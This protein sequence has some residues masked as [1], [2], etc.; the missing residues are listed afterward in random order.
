[1]IIVY[2]SVRYDL[3]VLLAAINDITAGVPLIGASSSGQ[4]HDGELFEQGDGLSVLALAGGGYQFGIG[5]ASGAEENPLET[6]RTLARSAREAAGPQRSPYETMLVLSDGLIGDQQELL[7]GIYRVAGFAVPVVGGA[8]GDDRQLT[9]TYVFCGDQ[10]LTDAAVALWIGSPRPLRVVAGHGWTPTG[11]PMIVTSVDGTLVREIAGRPAVEVYRENFRP[12]DP[13]DQIEGARPGYHS[14]HAFGLIQ[15][16][17]GMV[18][19]AALID[20]EGMLRTLTALPPYA[21]VQVVS[22]D[23]ED[24]LAVGADTIAAAVA[25]DEDAGVVLVFDCVARSDILADRRREEPRLLQRAA[26]RVPT[27]GMYTYGEFARTNSA[28]GYHNATI[29]AL[30]L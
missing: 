18:I 2:A 19:R 24:L 13:A 11:L 3:P 20:A 1:V 29:A 26:G 4:L 7:N 10:V 27:F 22:S 28:A 30:A 23:A 14:A 6:G 21:A 12:A 25:D 8:A 9:R 15:P 16:D 5:S 17:G